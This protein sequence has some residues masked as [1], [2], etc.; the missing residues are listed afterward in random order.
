M[1]HPA[2]KIKNIKT[3]NVKNLLGVTFCSYLQGYKNL[4]GSQKVGFSHYSPDYH[5]DQTCRSIPNA[6]IRQNPNKTLN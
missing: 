6:H 5:R 4:A 3:I 1:K 2:L